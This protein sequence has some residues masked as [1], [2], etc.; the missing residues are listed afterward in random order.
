YVF[1]ECTGLTAVTIPASVTSIGEGAFESCDSLTDI[2][3]DGENTAYASLDGVLLS[4]NQTELVCYPA[5]KTGAYAVP[6]TVTAI[7]DY[8]FYDC[9][10]LTT[11]AIGSG[12]TTIGEG[13][14]Y[15][16]E[17]LT[18]V[19]YAGSEE[20]W[21]AIAIGSDNECLTEA[22]IHYGTTILDSGTCGDGL[23]WTLDADGVLTVS[24]TGAIDDG[25]FAD[26]TDI[27][28]VVIED[29]ITAI[30]EAAFYGCESLT[31]V[32]IPD[33]V[34]AIGAMTFY[35]CTSLTAVTIPDSVT[36]VGEAAFAYCAGLTAVTIPDSVTTID[37]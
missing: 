37:G 12:V 34:T 23:I 33:R 17:S 4:K 31:A 3:V 28:A 24:G 25:A 29:G 6:D 9:S 20:D 1:S 18:D 5:G 13:A 8:A 19:Y 7:G 10:G 30:G 2:T 11:V 15:G 21:A 26:N 22:A 14:F 27:V 16:C 32:T 36:S 35:G